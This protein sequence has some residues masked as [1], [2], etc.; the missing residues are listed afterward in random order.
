[1]NTFQYFLVRWNSIKYN[2]ASRNFLKWPGRWQNKFVCYNSSL[3]L[4]NKAKQ[5]KKVLHQNVKENKRIG[6]PDKRHWKKGGASSKTV[7]K[8]D[9]VW[10][11][12]N[13]QAI[14]KGGKVTSRLQKKKKKKKC[15]SFKP[16][17][18]C[19]HHNN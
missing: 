10:L 17:L 3:P 14:N 5:N 9:I 6:N 18:L 2:A 16:L 19:P 4:K 12:I 13:N 7:A 15:M 8:T 1:M 11:N